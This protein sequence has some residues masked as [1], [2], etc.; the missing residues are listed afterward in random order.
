MLNTL[1]ATVLKRIQKSHT[2]RTILFHNLRF[3]LFVAFASMIL[4]KWRKIEKER[5]NRLSCFVIFSIRSK[6]NGSIN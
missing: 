3:N 5:E 2:H 4:F 1:T 6:L